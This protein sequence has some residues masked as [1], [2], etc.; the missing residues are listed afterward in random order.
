MLYQ[1]GEIYNLELICFKEFTA[2]GKSTY[3]AV[4]RSHDG[5][6]FVFVPGDT[7]TLGFDFK[8]KPLQ[9]IF[10]DENLTELVYPF[11][12]GYEEEIFSEDDV[13]TKISEALEDEEVLSN[14]ETYF[15]HNFTQEDE[16][17]I[18]P[19][20][21]QKEYSETCW[22]LIP[23][24]ML[25]Q[26]KEWQNMI[27]KAEEKGVSEVMVHNT[28]CLYKTDDS[29]WCGKLYE[30]TTFKKLLQDIKDNRYSLPTQREWEYLAG[31]GCRTIFPWGNN[32][33]FS[34]NLKHMEWMD[35]DGDYTLEKEN[36]FG[37]VIGDDPY[38]REIVYD[39]DEFSYKGGDGGRNIC[40]GLGVV[41]GGYLPISPYFQDSEMVIGDNI[42]GGYDFFRRVVRINDNM[43]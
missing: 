27:K 25:T 24:D 38:C 37:L 14:I 40:G 31:K 23:D 3:T 34:M 6:E 30:E 17:V 32:I 35:N 43:K 41:W 33:D 18:H 16:F 20:L 21:V 9:D 36:F 39:E 11:V 29:N 28:I 5:I 1:I 10:N 13:Q 26:N 15:K 8:N 7:V 2:F 22:S 12:E 4:Y 19:L 42:N